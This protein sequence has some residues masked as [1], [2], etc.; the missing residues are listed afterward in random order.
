[1]PGHSLVGSTDADAAERPAA[2]CSVSRAVLQAGTRRRWPSWPGWPDADGLDVAGDAP[3]LLADRTWHAT[4]ALL[5]AAAYAAAWTA[6]LGGAPAAAGCPAALRGRGR[7]G[8]R[9]SSAMSSVSTRIRARCMS[10][11]AVMTSIPRSRQP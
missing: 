1:M 3:R 4:P 10:G 5:G 7:P 6:G 8:G 2:C 11:R 9:C